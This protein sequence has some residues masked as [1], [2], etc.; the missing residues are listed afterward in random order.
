MGSSDGIELADLT[1]IASDKIERWGPVQ[2]G[3][4]VSDEPRPYCCESEAFDAWMY[5]DQG[6]PIN[7]PLFILSSLECTCNR[8]HWLDEFT[9]CTCLKH[10]VSRPELLTGIGS[11]CLASTPEE[12]ESKIHSV[13][14]SPGPANFCEH[15]SQAVE[16]STPRVNE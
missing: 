3:Y 16:L 1:I 8:Y 7:E 2:D 6:G 10:L 13:A 14:S 12:K 4:S 9:M 5:G 15:R 11:C